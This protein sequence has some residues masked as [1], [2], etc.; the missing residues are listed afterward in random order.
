[1][2]YWLDTNFKVSGSKRMVKF[3][4]DTEQDV[5]ILPHLHSEGVVQNDTVTHLPVSAGSLARAI[6]TSKL[7][8]LNSN[9][10]W[11]EQKSG[12]GGGDY[13]IATDEEVEEMIENLD[14]L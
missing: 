13:D 11:T 3:W 7:F 9:D 4:M 8:V 1:M 6:D 10:L 14:P 5:Q 12:G 2:A